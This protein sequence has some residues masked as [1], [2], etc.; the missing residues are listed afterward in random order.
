MGVNVFSKISI[1]INRIVDVITQGNLERVK[2]MSEFNRVFKDAF[3]SQ[4]FI[5]LC[6]VTTSYIASY[7]VLSKEFVRQLMAMGYDTLIIRG[8]SRSTGLEIP[9]KEIANL[10]DYMLD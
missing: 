3:Y 1:L 10:N 2:V 7:V 8:K 9:L 4:E 5:R 6:S